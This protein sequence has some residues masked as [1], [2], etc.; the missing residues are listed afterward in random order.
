[1]ENTNRPKVSKVEDWIDTG[2]TVVEILASGVSITVGVLTI[3]K[4]RRS[5]KEKFNDPDGYWS[6]KNNSD[7]EKTKEVAGA[8]NNLAKALLKS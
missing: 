8:I 7:L 3:F 2:K 1:M 6:R 5:L 4:C